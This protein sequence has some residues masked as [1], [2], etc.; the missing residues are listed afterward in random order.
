MHAL[1]SRYFFGFY[2][3]ESAMPPATGT[4]DDIIPGPTT[5][6]RD[7]G[8]FIGGLA[9]GIVTTSMMAVVI[10]LVILFIRGRK[11]TEPTP[12]ASPTK[13]A[14]IESINLKQKDVM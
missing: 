3:A 7:A 13:S 14:P 9:V 10:L 5:A 11:K 12:P 2:F 6:G 8:L 4:G 1:V